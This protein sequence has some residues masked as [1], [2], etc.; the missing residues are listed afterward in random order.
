MWRH[1]HIW[2][3]F[4]ASL[5]WNIAIWHLRGSEESSA[6]GEPPLFGPPLLALSLWQRPPQPHPQQSPDTSQTSALFTLTR[7]HRLLLCCLTTVL[8]TVT[9]SSVSLLLLLCLLQSFLLPAATSVRYRQHRLCVDC[10]HTYIVLL[11]WMPRQAHMLY[12]LPAQSSPPHPHLLAF[13]HRLTHT[14][15]THVLSPLTQA[16]MHTH[17]LS[18]PLHSFLCLPQTLPLAARSGALL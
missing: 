14:C 8:L 13:L 12:G 5:P 4:S 9:P 18:L 2:A 6:L 10:M 11:T 17:F 16:Y 3:S 7:G 1:S 15:S